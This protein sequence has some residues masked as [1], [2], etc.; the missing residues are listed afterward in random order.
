M[1]VGLK[2]S[3]VASKASSV[4][5]KAPTI[6]SKASTSSV[7]TDAP[8]TITIRHTWE[9]VSIAVPVAIVVWEVSV[10]VT[11]RETVSLGNTHNTQTPELVYKRDRDHK[12]VD[13]VY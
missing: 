7:T 11:M 8:I 13:A 3:S 1:F 12:S 5:S 9:L 4:S 6:P 2:S 10:G